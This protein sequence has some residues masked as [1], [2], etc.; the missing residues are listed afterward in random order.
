MR[1]QLPSAPPTPTCS[2]NQIVINLADLHRHADPAKAIDSRPDP[3]GG[4]LAG[5]FPRRLGRRGET[6][7]R[8][9]TRTCLAIASA[10]CRRHRPGDSKHSHISCPTDQPI[11]DRASCHSSPAVR[12]RRQPQHY[13]EADNCVRFMKPHRLNT[14]TDRLDKTRDTISRLG[15]TMHI[16][17]SD[18]YHTLRLKSA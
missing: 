14:S 15:K 3:M 16:N 7:G 1:V 10:G 4:A 9:A 17:I 2:Y 6:F 5:W 12:S 13:A 11:H 8:T 18:R